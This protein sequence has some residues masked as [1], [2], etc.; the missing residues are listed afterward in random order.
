MIGYRTVFAVL[1]TPA[2]VDAAIAAMTALPPADK[3][4]GLHVA[5]LA[6]A[7]GLVT[8][9]A[10][11]AYIEAQMQAIEAERTATEKAFVRACGAAGFAYEWRA[12]TA[13][14]V[15][16]SA[17]ALARAA[18]IILCP[19]IPSET[20]IA[21]HELAEVVFASGRPVLALPADRQHDTLGKRVL[22]AWDGGREAA[23]AT[24]DALPL[25]V[26]AEAVRV[27]SIQ[28][29]RH[30]PVRQFTLADDV[31]T[32]LARHGVRV[33]TSTFGSTRGSVRAE[34]E[35]QAL[36]FAADLTVMGCYGHSRLRERILGGVSR[37]MLKDIPSPLLL[38]S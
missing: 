36:D 11:A 7:Y 34:L 3:L 26:A 2:S 24:F 35:V 1:S 32:T 13:L 25:L 4:V 37:D 16:P 29:F 5:P 33:E 18:D 17:G 28:G 10:L 14:E 6:P 19:Q 22:V 20:A 30:D 21:R 8:D 27:V 9:M 23:R 15:S 31:C 38:A 12:A